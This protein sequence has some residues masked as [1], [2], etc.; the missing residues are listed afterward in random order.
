[1]PGRVRDKVAPTHIFGLTVIPGI[2]DFLEDLNPQLLNTITNEFDKVEGT[3]APQ[4]TRASSDLAGLTVASGPASG[5]TKGSGVDALDDLFPRV[6]IDGLLKGT[7]IL[8]DGK[9]D[10]WKT[11]KEALEAL[12]AL[13]DQGVNKRLKPQMG[14]S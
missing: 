3:P 8:A 5:K 4:P 11:K 14:K 2:K 10:A 13:L 1:L 12:Q 6:E 9:S 7:T